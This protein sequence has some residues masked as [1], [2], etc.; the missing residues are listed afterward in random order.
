MDRVAAA[1]KVSAEA[2]AAHPLM[3]IIAEL[4]VQVRVKHRTVAVRNNVGTVYCDAPIS[5][6]LGVGTF[7]RKL[8]LLREA[9]ADSCV[10]QALRHHYEEHS[11]ALDEKAE[12]FVHHRYQELA[13]R[14]HEL[15]E[16]PHPNRKA[17]I[18]A[19]EAGLRSFL[20]TT[21]DMLEAEIDHLRGA[22]DTPQ[23]LEELRNACG[24]RIREMEHDLDRGI[25]GERAGLLSGFNHFALVD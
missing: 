2:R 9:A 22:L 14:L 25:T 24:G 15:K 23:R 4:G 16:T 21:I 1:G 10:R 19:F 20:P 17:A 3:L 13:A 7:G 6:D 11:R 8:I 12:E 18:R 5:V